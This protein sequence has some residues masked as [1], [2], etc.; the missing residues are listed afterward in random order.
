MCK[1]NCSNQPGWQR[2]LEGGGEI[3]RGINE[4]NEDTNS[5]APSDESLTPDPPPTIP[6]HHRTALTN[7]PRED[8]RVEG[9]EDEATEVDIEGGHIPISQGD[10]PVEAQPPEG[11]VEKLTRVYGDCVHQNDG[12]HL[13]GGIRDDM[14]WQERWKKIVGLP[15]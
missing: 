10:I 3:C 6:L 13:D 15:P 5:I 14:V 4:A 7:E 8:P 12:T 9:G 1:R 2:Q 11:V